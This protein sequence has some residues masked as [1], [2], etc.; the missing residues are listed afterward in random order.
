MYIDMYARDPLVSRPAPSPG[1]FPGSSTATSLDGNAWR[2]MGVRL[3]GGFHVTSHI[4][5]MFMVAFYVG[6]VLLI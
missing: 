6:L 3:K 4:R 5:K 2:T 1:F